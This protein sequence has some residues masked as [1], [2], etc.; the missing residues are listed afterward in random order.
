MRS[1]LAS[2][3]ISLTAL[4][5]SAAN[6]YSASLL[7]NI[8][9]AMKMQ[10]A[11]E[12]LPEGTHVEVLSYR[13]K[14]VTVVV[15]N[16]RVS[17]IGYSLFPAEQRLGAPSPFYDLAER[18]ALL[19]DVPIK[20]NKTL[21]REFFEEGIHF[22]AGS[23]S[24]LP[25]LYKADGVEFSL[26]NEDGKK[27]RAKWSRGG[28]TVCEIEVPF[29]YS[30]L[31]GTTMEENEGYLIADLLEV[32]A[33]H[34]DSLPFARTE[35]TREQ[36]LA[37]FP[38]S[39]YVLP[40]EAYYF[41]NLNS[42]RYY[43]KADSTTFAPIL[44]ERYLPE[45]FANIATSMEVPNDLMMDVKVVQ[46]NYRTTTVHMPL[47]GFVNYC[48]KQGCTPF[49]G[50]M[51]DKGHEINLML[52]MRNVDEGYCHLLKLTTSRPA[53]GEKWDKLTARLNPYIPISKISA[54]FAD[55]TESQQVAPR[56]ARP[57]TFKKTK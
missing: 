33:V 41:D 18:Y 23:I 4:C 42:N 12:A 27:Y 57:I 3:A 47:S 51:E 5:S 1:L 15:S 9:G 40:G 24:T 46:Y 2:V 44:D 25:S 54:L 31:H 38:Y 35:P 48:L 8:A 52:I 39:Y 30:L 50:V 22:D 6:G 19:A 32:S 34:P 16:N 29:T 11:I 7:A 10:Q 53:Y 26:A 36:L 14:P 43:T 49:F 17:H 55:Q 13:G 56:A 21:E 28:S 37:T 20:R 45:S